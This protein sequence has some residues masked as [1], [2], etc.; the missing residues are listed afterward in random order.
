MSEE[1]ITEKTLNEVTKRID[2]ENDRQNNRLKKLEDDMGVL[3]KLSAS[4]EKLAISMEY[5]AKEVEKQGK[6][7]NDLEMKPA[8]RYDL[9]ITTLISGLLGALIGFLTSGIF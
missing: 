3:Y 8:K 9:I 5:L 2:Q 7:L 1:L 4:I 6:Q